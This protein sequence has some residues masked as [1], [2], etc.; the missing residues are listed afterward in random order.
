MEIWHGTKPNPC[1]TW[2]RHANQETI[3]PRPGD[4]S[5]DIF[6]GPFV[7]LLLLAAAWC[8]HWRRRRGDT[9]P[10]ELVGELAEW[11]EGD[12][13]V[14]EGSK[15]RIILNWGSERLRRT[16]GGGKRFYVRITLQRVRTCNKPRLVKGAQS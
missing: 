8:L 3:K 6:S 5:P 9:H 2:D 10:G 14:E 16:V 12:G 1:I 4:H 13:R 11:A 7:L 15:W